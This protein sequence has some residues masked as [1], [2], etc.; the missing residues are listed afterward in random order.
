MG[1]CPAEM[2]IEMTF[3]VEPVPGKPNCFRV[4]RDC[5]GGKPWHPR[6][7]VD[8]FTPTPKKGR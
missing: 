5:D 3:R 1:R 7:M 2:E 8:R 6:K 4:F